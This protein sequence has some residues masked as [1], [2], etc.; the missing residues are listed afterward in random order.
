[1][2]SNMFTYMNEY[3]KLINSWPPSNTPDAKFQPKRS[4]KIKN[5]RKKK[6]R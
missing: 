4:K 5:K 1:M 6:K 2:L 3:S